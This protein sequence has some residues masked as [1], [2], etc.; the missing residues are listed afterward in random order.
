MAS[1]NKQ[2]AIVRHAIFVAM[3]SRGCRPMGK[4]LVYKGRNWVANAEE[5]SWLDIAKRP[6]RGVF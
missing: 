6:F 4:S 2:A 1:I 5:M 3:V